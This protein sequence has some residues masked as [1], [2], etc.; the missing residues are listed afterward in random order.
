MIDTNQMKFSFDHEAIARDFVI[1]EARRDS[2][3]YDKSKVP[4]V[5][6]Q[7]CRALAVA[8]DWGNSCYILYQR[9][10]AE[11]ISLK[12]TL[13]G[14]ESDVQV[15][16]IASSQLAEKQSFRLA[17][18]LCN[19]IPS[20][21]SGCK[22]FHNVTGKLYYSEPGWIYRKNEQL[23][24]LW[25]LQIL[26]TRENCVSIGVKTFSNLRYKHN[27]QDKPQYLLDET[28]YALRRA[29]KEEPDKS[30]ERFI[31]VAINSKR[32]NTVPFLEFGS[33]AEYRSCKVGVF[34]RFL[35]DTRTLLAPY[36]SL[37]LTAM[38]ESIHIGTESANNS[39]MDIRHRLKQC[40]LYLED[41][42]VS[43]QSARL[44]SMLRQELER[45]SGI[46][47]LDGAPS[48][49]AAL[50]RI[51]HSEEYYESMNEH[52][53]YA[54]APKNCVV[55]HVTL[56]DFH[57]SG[58]NRC[59]T[60][61]KEDASLR[62]IIQELA[63]KLDI[64]QGVMGCYNWPALGF[65]LPV[66]F[67][68]ANKGGVGKDTSICYQRL[69]IK[70]DG[71]LQFDTWEQMPFAEDREKEQIAFAFET[72]NGKIDRQVK[73]LVYED[74]DNIHIIYDTDRYTLP[75]MERLE[76]ILSATRDET[77]I[78]VDVIVEAMQAGIKNL[79]AAEQE[80]CR[81]IIDGL[82]S[83]KPRVS[84][85]ELKGILNLRTKL[86]KKLNGLI[87]ERTGFLINSGLKQKE[88]RELFFGGTLDIRHFCEGDTQYY[89]S[90]YHGKSLN[91]TLAHACRIRKVISTGSILQFERYL[92]LLEVDFVR[93]SAWTVVPFPFKY[94]REWAKNK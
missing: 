64:Y 57:L 40:P 53:I 46:A 50:I 78:L 5:A 66:N 14:Y 71:K 39:M 61:D 84:R 72:K 82:Q 25:V 79:D 62:K 9:A 41:A 54:D 86:G 22:M 43:E 59:M 20:L 87:F 17:Q 30:G 29:L 42:V 31:P 10:S 67:V 55:Q 6:L 92:P 12:R 27:M 58:M 44:A 13:E 18:L 56:E 85:K 3:N 24:G 69:E 49:N 48:E 90:G 80:R 94:L 34:Q 75:N 88:N 81:I 74:I 16:E 47:L 23:I 60:Q 2:G 51:I 73:G 1:F 32:K 35:Q 7:E 15:R 70:P 38:D 93:A 21:G 77:T 11:K 83:Y 8:Y 45:Y 68:T 89:Y 52:D 4:D 37:E 19:A 26:F 65:L 28:N 91:R 76:Q 33:L 36:L 63:I